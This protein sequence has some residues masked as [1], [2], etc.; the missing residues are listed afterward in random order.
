[1]VFDPVLSFFG[2]HVFITFREVPGFF[3]GSV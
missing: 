1:M 3:M 2:D